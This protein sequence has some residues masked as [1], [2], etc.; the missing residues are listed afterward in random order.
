[1][2]LLAGITKN[3][4]GGSEYVKIVHGMIEGDAP[5]LDL[6]FEKRLQAFVLVAIRNRLV[7]SAHDVSE[8]GLAVALTE[9]CIADREYLIGAKVELESDIRADALYFGESQSR[10][11]LSINPTNKDNITRLAASMNVPLAVIGKV[12]GDRL[13]INN[14]INLPTRVL[15]DEYYDSIGRTMATKR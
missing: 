9:C 11:I 2:I 10:V 5:A 15:A 3:E 12:G 1:L 7:K 14:D 8:G 4:F 13:M 6:E